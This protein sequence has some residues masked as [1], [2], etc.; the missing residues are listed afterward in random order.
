MNF[1][2]KLFLAASV[3]AIAV[4]AWAPS[5]FAQGAR[6]RTDPE[7]FV[8]RDLSREIANKMTGEYTIALVGDVLMQEP[9]GMRISPAIREV[10]QNADTTIGNNETFAVDRRNWAGSNGYGNNWTP[11][12]TMFDWAELGFDMMGAGEGAGG[13]EGMASTFAIAQEAGIK[14]TGWGPNLNIARQPAF[15][16]LPQGRVAYVYAYPVGPVGDPSD[17]ARNNGDGNGSKERPGMNVLRLTQHV[18][19]TAEQLEQIREMRASMV[20]RRD[21]EEGLARVI[22]VPSEQDDRVEFLGTTYRLGDEPGDYIYVMNSGDK[23]AQIL[24]VREAKEYADFVVY[25]MHTH[26]NRFVF[27]AYSHDHQPVDYVVELAHEMV[28]NGM[29]IYH[30]HGNHTMA[31]IE[32]YKGRPIFYNLGNFSVHRFGFDGINDTSS[33]MTGIEDGE[34]GEHY[35]QQN[36]NLVAMMAEVDYVDGVPTEVRIH[37]IDLGLDKDRPWSRMNIPMTPSPER[38]QSILEDIQDYSEPWGTEIEIRDGVGYIT[39]DPAEYVTVGENLRDT[40]ED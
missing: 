14:M 9:M 22:D 28:D 16:E 29:D 23:A 39:I 40:F 18:T 32:I 2:S 36:N 38:A 12:E 34:L 17:A 15:Q 27:Q 24:T 20:A 7:T 11:A 6:P 13:N 3:T 4:S 35:F 30:G 25:S 21:T 31:G 33:G 19:V 8:Y 26:E 5:A 37:P 1:K 10:L